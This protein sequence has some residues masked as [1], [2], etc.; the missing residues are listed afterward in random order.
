MDYD[1]LN[2]DDEPTLGGVY[3]AAGNGGKV[4][5]ASLE[6]SE[7]EDRPNGFLAT[8]VP[9]IAGTHLL[10]VTYKVRVFLVEAW[11]TRYD[12]NNCALEDRHFWHVSS[13]Q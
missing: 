10:N 12:M 2:D 6:F 7:D 11:D 3:G 1:E 8:Y 13:I 5:T 9:F 4:V